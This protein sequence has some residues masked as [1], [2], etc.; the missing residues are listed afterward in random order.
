MSIR[1]LDFRDIIKL[2]NNS[3]SVSIDN[4]PWIA[5]KDGKWHLYR[6]QYRVHTATIEFNLL[7]LASDVTVDSMRDAVRHFVAGQTHVVYATSLEQRHGNRI[8]Q[9]FGADD[10][11]LWSAKAYLYS[12]IRE[13]LDVYLTKLKGL[14][15]DLYI[16]PQVGTPI[17]ARK[18][19]P[20]P[21]LATLKAPRF[22]EET[23]EGLIVLLGEPG[24]GKTYMSQHIVSELAKSRAHVPVYINSEQWESMSKEQ[25]GDLEKT[26][27]H[28][29]RYF[30]APIAWAE[31]DPIPRTK[32]GRC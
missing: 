21:L 7:Y 10:H 9:L 27:T 30:E 29:F 15:P 17:G 20:N 14:A 12:H 2:L 24:Q 23:T 28:S 16:P 19:V 6:A 3:R 13:E 1:S 8:R 25:L 26:I 4:V 18:K 31:V 32:N 11:K 22:E 5:A